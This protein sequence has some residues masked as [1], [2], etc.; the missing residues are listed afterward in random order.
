MIVTKLEYNYRKLQEEKALI[1]GEISVKGEGN[2]K[3]ILHNM[4]TNLVA[5]QYV[6]QNF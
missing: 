4:V 6:L 1:K 3:N 2:I 5:I